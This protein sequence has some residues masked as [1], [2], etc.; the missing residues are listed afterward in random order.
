[1]TLLSKLSLATLSRS[2]TF[3]EIQNIFFSQKSSPDVVQ[4]ALSLK[5]LATLLKRTLEAT[6]WLPPKPLSWESSL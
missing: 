2:Q 3:P 1:M 6:H 4:E 5:H